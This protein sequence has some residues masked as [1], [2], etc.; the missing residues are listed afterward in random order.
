MAHDGELYINS[1]IGEITHLMDTNFQEAVGAFNVTLDETANN[2]I[3]LINDVKNATNIDAIISLSADFLNFTTNVYGE[4]I[5]KALQ[6]KEIGNQIIMDIDILSNVGVGDPD[7]QKILDETKL[8]IEKIMHSTNNIGPDSAINSDVLD[9]IELFRENLGEIS[10]M[11]DGISENFVEKYFDG[12]NSEIANIADSLREEKDQ[13]V[14]I[15]QDLNIFSDVNSDIDEM[16]QN[17]T[18][19]YNYFYLSL[20]VIGSLVVIILVLIF[21][22]LILSCCG[23]PGTSLASKSSTV[24]KISIGLFLGIGVIFFILTVLFFVIGAFSTKLV[25]QTLEEPENSDLVTLANPAIESELKNL[26]NVPEGVDFHFDL[27]DFIKD[28]IKGKAIYPLLNMEY[29]YNITELEE[30]QTT[31]NIDEFVQ[32]AEEQIDKT[33]NS[34]AGYSEVI[35]DEMKN[36]IKETSCN[37]DNLLQTLEWSVI[38]DKESLDTLERILMKLEEIQN[39]TYPAVNENLDNLVQNV[40]DFVN[41]FK[42]L[43]EFITINLENFKCKE[44]QYCFNFSGD[45]DSILKNLENTFEYIENQGRQ[46]IKDFFQ[47]NMEKLLAVISGFIDYA[48]NYVQK[49]LGSTLPIGRV[50]SALIEGLCHNILDP[51]NSGTVRSQIKKNILNISKMRNNETVNEVLN[52]KDLAWG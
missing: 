21:I 39:K 52:F 13:L 24:F 36:A 15:T 10:L 33:I 11:I 30:W 26:L 14:N 37:V 46:K 23:S 5:K 16:S 25:C 38:L 27:A 3:S 29:I 6:I 1:T 40:D 17:L 41:S 20:V 19:Y 48:I 4:I 50:Y 43:Q 47:D 51:F 9:V 35:D 28:V 34:V 22:G 12:I 44:D 8:A 32:E 31:Y 49:E 42:N 7:L 18:E 45:V 2:F